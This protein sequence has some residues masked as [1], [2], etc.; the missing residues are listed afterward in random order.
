MAVKVIQQLYNH[1]RCRDIADWNVNSTFCLL[2]CTLAK[3][4]YYAA[5]LVST[6]STLTM[7]ND[8]NQLIYRLM[9]VT[10]NDNILPRPLKSY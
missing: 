6:G 1:S 10:N 7:M 3:L 2:A 4:F 9:A 8:D 5:L